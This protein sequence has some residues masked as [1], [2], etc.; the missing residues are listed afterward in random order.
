M[1]DEL[2]Q[3]VDLLA[4]AEDNIGRYITFYVTAAGALAALTVTEVFRTKFTWL[5]KLVLTLA[6]TT[7]A[8]NNF[9]NI[10]YYHH[11]Y[12]AAVENLNAC[13]GVAYPWSELFGTESGVFSKKPLWHVYVGHF[14]ADLIVTMLIW[15]KNIQEWWAK[16]R[17]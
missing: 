5:G 6:L 11:V 7:V 16:R 14:A 17:G 15:W 8:W 1:L 4:F 9:H 3:L 2:R 10:V 13:C 12:N